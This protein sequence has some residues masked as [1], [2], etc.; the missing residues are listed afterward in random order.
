MAIF[1]G[2]DSSTVQFYMFTIAIIGC[3][4]SGLLLSL[5]PQDNL[6]KK[7][8]FSLKLFTYFFP[9][10]LVSMNI[11]LFSAYFDTE[12]PLFEGLSGLF[13]VLAL[14]S[15]YAA[16]CVR[17]SV[18][19]HQ[20]KKFIRLN[21]FVWCLLLIPIVLSADHDEVSKTLIKLFLLTNVGVLVFAGVIRLKENSF[22]NKGEN[23]LRFVLS[24]TFIYLLTITVLYELTG[25]E[26]LYS[27]NFAIL[28]TALVILMQGSVFMIF[29]F[30]TIEKHKTESYTD[31]LTNIPNRRAF[32]KKMNELVDSKKKSAKLRSGVVVVCD[33]DHFKRVNDNYG[34]DAGDRVLQKLAD[35]LR[36]SLR[37]M[38][39]CAR[40]G[41]EEFAIY[42]DDA[43]KDTAL[44]ALERIRKTVESEYVLIEGNEIRVT[45]SFGY[46]VTDHNYNINVY[47]EEADVALYEA[48]SKGRNQ[49]VKFAGLQSKF[50][51]HKA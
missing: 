25:D 24:S 34:H 13:F 16:I 15:L 49:I 44:I 23:L 39:Y 48:K 32:I 26:F 37:N 45:M 46:V 50:R 10:L 27:I 14:W 36:S 33:I 41:G 40:L 12:T 51:K 19:E 35:I 2:A 38:D 9:L 28:S 11:W 42:L 21:L 8:Q 6:T 18:K 30:D 17:K 29:I 22:A 43:N 47:L 1:S 20:I 4:V 3:S 31:Y 5:T 7:D